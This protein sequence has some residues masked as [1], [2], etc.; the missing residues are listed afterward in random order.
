MIA[1]TLSIAGVVLACVALALAL[2]LAQRVRTLAEAFASGN[3]KD[4]DLPRRGD[5]VG[6][7]RVTTLAGEQLSQAS[8]AQG[9]SLVGYFTAGCSTCDTV[10]A[11][12]REQPPRLP[13]LAVVV[14][15]SDEPQ[16]EQD[17]RA[18]AQKLEALAKVAVVRPGAEVTRAFRD[19][20]FPTL[21]RVR[22]GAVTA[23]GHRISDVL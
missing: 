2:A 10:R 17:A 13:L 22:D 18:V 19:A 12:L 14:A 20:G 1:L 3:V 5:R 15:H 6:T 21:V 7:F 9:E 16:D 4:Q 8:L 23:A 11:E